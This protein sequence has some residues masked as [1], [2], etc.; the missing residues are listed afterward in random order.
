MHVEPRLRDDAIGVIEF[1]RLGEVG[2]IAGVK[3]PLPLPR[4]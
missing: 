4:R 2:D 1:G 3:V